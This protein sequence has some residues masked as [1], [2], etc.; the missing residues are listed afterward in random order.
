MRPVVGLTLTALLAAVAAVHAQPSGVPGVAPPPAP[1]VPSPAPAPPAPP[2]DP[3]LD[4]HLQAWEKRMGGTTNF[5]ADIELERTEAVFKKVRKFNGSVLCM[6]PNL[7]ILRLESALDKTDYEAFVCTGQFVY[8]YN[9]L[10]KTVTEYK[11]PAGAAP[12]ASDN[13]MLDF[14]SGMKT[15]DVKRR[16]DITLF[17]QDEF[18]VY[19]DI[20]PRRDTDKQDFLQVRFALF[21]PKTQFAYLPSQVWMMKPNGDTELWKFTKPQTD[22]PG[23]TKDVFKYSEVP[24]FAFKKAES[25]PPK[26]AG[27]LPG[28]TGLPPG[29][30][31]VKPK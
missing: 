28:G 4:P 3:K 6:K 7:A 24:G 21:G 13:L 1:G 22:I 2:A 19:L 12:G 31:A 25:L 17:N 9:G 16:F 14:L 11:I 29:P 5:R 30:G 18:Y 10:A 15:D 8:E 26:P 27:A 23:V 20:K